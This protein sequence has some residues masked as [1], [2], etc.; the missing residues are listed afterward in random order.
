MNRVLLVE[1]DN[2]LGYILKEYLQMHDFEVVWAKD[3]EIGLDEFRKNLFD[4]C[5]LDVMMPKK[6]GFTLAEEIKKLQ[7]EIPLIF[8]T[9]KSMKIDK[10]KGFKV[11]CDDY[12]I[13][14][15]DEEE[16]IAR[17]QAVL[18]RSSKQC[19]KSEHFLIGTFDFHTKNQVLTQGDTT[20]HLTQK[21]SKILE[22]LCSDLGELVER[23]HILHVLWG[24]NSYF[25]RRS[26]D[27]FISKLRKYLEADAKVKITNVHGKGY[28]L[29]A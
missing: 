28:I 7:S 2:S 3:G 8:L 22:M 12:I 19:S 1:D 20:V 25:K 14:P 27:V 10:L 24:D 11:G 15:V 16:L 17:I 4:I 13:K 21:E 26:M 18:R 29:E 5:V 23:D 9:A 6:D